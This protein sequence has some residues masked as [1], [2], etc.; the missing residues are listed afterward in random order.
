MAVDMSPAAV[1]RRLARMGRGWHPLD[2]EEARAM[3]EPHSVAG[4]LSPAAVQRRLDEL[5]ALCELT[6]YLHAHRP[7]R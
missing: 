7:A 2:R 3:L 6:G 4:D 5:R 1:A